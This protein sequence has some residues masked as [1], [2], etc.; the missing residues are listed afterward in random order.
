MIYGFD[1]AN[2]HAAAGAFLVYGIYRSR[3]AK[4]FKVTPD[5][6]GIIERAVKGSAKRAGDL[7]AFIEHLKPKLKCGAVHPRYMT[8]GT[9]P[10][11]TFVKDPETGELMGG[12][13]AGREFWTRALEEA[14][15]RAVLDALYGKTSWVIAL[16]RDRLEREKPVEG[17][18]RDYEED[19]GL[20]YEG[21]G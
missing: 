17:I 14:D 8:S 4:R 3:D 1:T 5:M 9:A 2:E 13:A 21:D 15:H 18:M 16:V 7:H 10:T 20:D 6:W 12:V 19:E 11:V